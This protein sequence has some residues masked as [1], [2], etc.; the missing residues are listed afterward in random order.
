MR[1]L[2]CGGRGYGVAENLVYLRSIAERS[3]A[4]A[5]AREQVDKM[6][7]TLDRIHAEL[8]VSLLISGGAPGADSV[9]LRWAAANEI[10][11]QVFKADWKAHGRAAGVIR[12][13]Q[14]LDIARPQLVVAFPGSKGTADMV[15]RSRAKGVN[16]IEVE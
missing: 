5:F 3:A 10:E 14:M 11:C 15:R 6:F 4:M 12:N 7:A 1:V 9:A 13:Q 16:V 2:V 8:T